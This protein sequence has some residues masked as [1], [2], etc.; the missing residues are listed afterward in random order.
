[1]VHVGALVDL[2][3]P[4]VV[5]VVGVV[6][7]LI[8]VVVAKFAVVVAIVVLVVFFV[9]AFLQVPFVFYKF[10][11]QANGSIQTVIKH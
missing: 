9:D 7:A 8:P 11:Q 3:L 6:P 1:M 10:F 5:A 2:H 4:E